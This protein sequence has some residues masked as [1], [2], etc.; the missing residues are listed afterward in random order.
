[1]V[2]DWGKHELRTLKADHIVFKGDV[3]TEMLQRFSFHMLVI[4]D[5]L[6]K[7]M[8]CEGPLTEVV[9]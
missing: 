4:G 8:N 7:W 1:L 5:V 9:H 6:C 3:Q 2:E